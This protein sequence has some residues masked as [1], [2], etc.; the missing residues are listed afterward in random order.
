MRLP[1]RAGILAAALLAAGAAGAGGGNDARSSFRI[2]LLLPEDAEVARAMRRGAELAAAS[3][4]VRILARAPGTN[5]STQAERAAALRFEDGVDALL[6]PPD[7]RVAHAAAQLATR[8]R[9]PLVVLADADALTRIGVPWLERVVPE[10]RALLGALF[11]ETPPA[12]PVAVVVDADEE[13]R[14]LGRRAAAAALRAGRRTGTP[15]ES[16]GTPRST[17][18]VARQILEGGFGAVLLAGSPL[19]TVAL[20]E[21]LDAAGWEGFRLAGPEEDAALLAARAARAAR[22]VVAPVRFDAAAD[23]TSAAFEEAYIA[24]YDET[25]RWESAAAHEAVRLLAA[26]LEAKEG[27][28]PAESRRPAPSPPVRLARIGPAGRL[29]PLHLEQE[30]R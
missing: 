11:A 4:D 26:R 9:I 18:S 3:L 7:R 2:G 5:W 19:R 29:D 30:T 14:R 22:G 15:L 21:R 16:D 28:A 8:T 24:R 13:G 25:P 17:E 23:A 27:T 1:G 6:A 12:S 20:L 10:E